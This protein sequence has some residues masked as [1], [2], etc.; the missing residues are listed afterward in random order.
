MPLAGSM[1]TALTWFLVVILLGVL[2]GLLV[3][4]NNRLTGTRAVI[5]CIDR[6]HVPDMSRTHA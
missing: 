2:G 5:E 3:G 6:S 1:N 4:L